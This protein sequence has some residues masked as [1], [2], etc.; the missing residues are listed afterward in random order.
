[1]CLREPRRT[2]MSISAS[3]LLISRSRC[4]AGRNVKERAF[5][6]NGCQASW[7]HLVPLGQRFH[8]DIH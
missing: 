5:R 4:Q 2:E 3:L 1:M 7:N 8:R 6:V